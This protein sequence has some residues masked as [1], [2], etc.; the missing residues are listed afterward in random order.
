MS[1]INVKFSNQSLFTDDR[2]V[3]TVVF[4][5]NNTADPRVRPDNTL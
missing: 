3:N 1:N 4:K 5:M 2:H